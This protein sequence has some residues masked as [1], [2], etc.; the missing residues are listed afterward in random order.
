MLQLSD[1][2]NTQ[3]L[4]GVA[5]CLG[6]VGVITRAYLPASNSGLPLPPSP[7]N[8]RLLGHSL[9]PRNAFLTVAEWIDEY[10]P[11]IT[12]RAGTENVV[13]I[14]RHKAAMDIMEKHGGLLADRPRMS[15]GQMLTGGLTIAFVR[16]GDRFRRM[17]RALHTHL[18]PKAA[19]AYQPS[20][21]SFAKNTVL[22]ILNDPHNFQNHAIS[23][24]VTTIMTVAY[25]KTT[26]T[27]ATDPDVRASCALVLTWWTPSPGS[28]NLPWYG[29]KLRREFESNGKLFASQMNGLK[30]RLQNNVELGPS[31]GKYLLENQHLYNLTEMEMH[32][33]SG[34][35]FAAGTD[36]SSAAI[37]TVLMAAA[38]F[39][40][41]Q[42][43]VQAELDTV[44]GRD[45]APTFSDQESLPL[46]AAFISEAQRWRPLGPNGFPHRTT[47]DVVWENYCIPAGTTVLGSHWA[48]SRDA[49]VYPEPYVFKPQ[50]WINDEGRL[51][52]DLTFCFYGFGRRICPGQHLANR[53]MFI[54]LVLVLWAFQ[55]T[56]DPTKPLDDMGFM[57]IEMPN[58]PCPIE[59]KP[60]VPDTEL[61][62]IMQNYP[63]AE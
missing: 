27:S 11:L 16:V 33:L 6:V 20:Q 37:C 5:A 58:V 41:E 44:I 57:N 54:N 3:I 1:L 25:G 18:Q 13:I 17:R 61:R 29:Q 12:I 2:P 28:E 56:L 26:S 43:K 24:A 23:Y 59:F 49:E 51:R 21:M 52:D 46:L 4:L 47:K 8:W 30:Q 55:L 32:Y 38:C 62:R 53:S 50:R 36:S 14:G 42:A 9:P 45:R 22:N 7:P 63:E 19:E 10:G 35:F 39:P 15:A 31:F 48:I 34:T 40:E 60:R